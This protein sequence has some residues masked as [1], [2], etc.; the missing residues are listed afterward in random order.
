MAVAGVLAL[1]VY[2]HSLEKEQGRKTSRPESKQR[3]ILRDAWQCW[4][5]WLHQLHKLYVS[6]NKGRFRLSVC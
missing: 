5:T 2:C 3:H 6:S 1:I 4:H